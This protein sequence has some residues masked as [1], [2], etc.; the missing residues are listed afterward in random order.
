M[1]KFLA[2]VLA[3]CLMTAILP[4]AAEEAGNLLTLFGVSGGEGDAQGAVGTVPEGDSGL[5][6]DSF[7]N[8]FGG[9][10]KGEKIYS[11]EGK[12]ELP[13][14]G[15]MAGET[16][17][18]GG[19]EIYAGDGED[20]FAEIGS[21]LGGTGTAEHEEI[22][23]GDGEDA[24]GGLGGAADELSES[25]SMF[26]GSSRGLDLGS[27]FGGNSSGID[28]DLSSL[29]SMFGGD[30]GGIDLDLGSLLGG[31]GSGLD[32]DLGSLGSMFSGDGSGLDLDLGSLGSL[33][34]GDGSGLD[35][36]SLG[37]LLGGDGSGFDLGSMF[38]GDGSGFDLGG[39]LGGDGSGLN[40]GGL[41][42]G[43]ETA[44]V[45]TVPAENP[46][47]FYGTW[48][49]S[50][51]RV[52]GYEIGMDML[53]QFGLDEPS[54][55]TATL[56]ADSVTFAETNGKTGTRAITAVDFSDGALTITLDSTPAKLQ[57]TDTGNLLC[58]VSA[59]QY[60]IDASVDIIFTRAQ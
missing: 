48:E 52:A 1:K 6:T 51:L 33:F 47:Q 44:P 55:M 25:D 24:L 39:L 34:G 10:D 56:T 9:T 50:S 30:G 19:G 15:N 23:A 38:G 4:A 22:Y 17:N 26:S 41:L 59:A 49:I 18:A 45:N 36:G 14:S 58:T 7:G 13:G 37:G 11:D 32:L 35:L 40:L 31:D 54:S 57:L 5:N 46:E 29:G 12:D 53:K 2:L 42:G 28:L 43:G 21:M 3:F 27:L 20:I 60:G 16:G 8:M